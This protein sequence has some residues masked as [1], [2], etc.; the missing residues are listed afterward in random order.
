VSWFAVVSSR[1]LSAK[2]FILPPRMHSR[3]SL[4]KRG[5]SPLLSP[6]ASNRRSSH[7]PLSS[8][9]TGSGVLLTKAGISLAPG[10]TVSTESPLASILRY[11]RWP[12]ALR[13]N[14]EPFDEGGAL[15]L[16]RGH[17]RVVPRQIFAPLDPD[18][19]RRERERLARVGA[20][21]LRFHL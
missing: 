5:Y 8:T 16:D 10:R 11:L 6:M 3:S 1:C 19:D 7:R 21:P 13:R 17:V 18:G 12:L 14:A 15:L 2:H 20:E 9:V 4:G